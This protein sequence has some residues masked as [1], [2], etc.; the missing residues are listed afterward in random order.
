MDVQGFHAVLTLDG[1]VVTA[2]CNDVSFDRQKTVETKATMDGTGIPLKLV[3]AKD[4]TLELSGQ[5]DTAG[6][7]LLEATFDK[8]VPVE[9]SA[10]IGDGA[11]I[12]AGTYAGDVTIT[13]M[14]LDASAADAWNFSLSAEGWLTF[15]PPV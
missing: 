10:E 12:D 14:P 5:V 11:T 13:G 15:T 4:G 1:N 6:Q 9:F 3:T 7:T 2:Y 8:D